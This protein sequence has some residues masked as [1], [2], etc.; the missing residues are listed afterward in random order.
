MGRFPLGKCHALSHPRLTLIAYYACPL[1][2]CTLIYKEF[3]NHYFSSNSLIFHTSCTQWFINSGSHDCSV[4]ACLFCLHWV[5]FFA[6]FQHFSTYLTC[7]YANVFSLGHFDHGLVSWI[8]FM[9]FCLSHFHI[10]RN[11]RSGYSLSSPRFTLSSPIF[12]TL[13]FT[14]S[15]HHSLFFLI[16]AMGFR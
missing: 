8:M 6:Q 5:V 14:M 2:L 12:R 7:Y 3:P 11:L 1:V 10:Y 15:D 9:F 16:D 13:S 4:W